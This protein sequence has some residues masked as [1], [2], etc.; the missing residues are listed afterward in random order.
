MDSVGMMHGHDGMMD[1]WMGAWML[2][3][4][5]VGVAV[6][7]LVVV[8]TVWLVRNMAPSRSPSVEARRELDLRYARGE[9]DSQDYDERLQRIGQPSPRR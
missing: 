3:W 7:G 6:L 9:I 5:L 1:G 8:A 2:V 4:A